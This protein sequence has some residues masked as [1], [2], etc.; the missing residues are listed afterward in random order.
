MSNRRNVDVDFRAAAESTDDDLGAE[1]S[2]S[3][4]SGGGGGDGGLTSDEEAGPSNP[5]A[6]R[7]RKA[8]GAVP[9]KVEKS[10]SGKKVIGKGKGKGKVWEGEF[11]HT[12][13]TVRED[14]RGTLE[15]AVS[16][17]LLSSKTR[18]S[19]YYLLCRRSS[20]D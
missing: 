14:E 7:I 16:D 5:R 15:G 10:V 19:V 3:D 13:D 6:K 17:M 11:V 12:W 1:L 4:L 9:R 8:T 18:R 2:E 20:W